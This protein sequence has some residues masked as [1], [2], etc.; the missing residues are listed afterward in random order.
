[1]NIAQQQQNRPLVLNPLPESAVQILRQGLDLLTIVSAEDYTREV[2]LAFN[3]TMGGHYRHCLE[4]FQILLEGAN[5]GIINYEAR[6]RNEI[7][8]TDISFA[9]QTTRDMINQLYELRNDLLNIPLSVLSQTQ[10]ESVAHQKAESTFKRELMYGVAH[11]IHHYALI[12]VMASYLNIELPG[13]FGVAPS[14]IH[15][16]A[17]L[18]NETLAS[19]AGG[20]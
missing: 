17:T 2:P 10:Y 13:D 3:A 19:T 4:H 11:A 14:T 1:V 15:H 6:N 9:R 12:G 7:I 8:E 18:E 5:S 16:R 20:L